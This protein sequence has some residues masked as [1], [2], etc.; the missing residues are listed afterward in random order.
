MRNLVVAFHILRR[1]I[2]IDPT[3]H[4]R[5]ARLGQILVVD[6]TEPPEMVWLWSSRQVFQ[7]HSLQQRA[8]Q[9]LVLRDG[10]VGRCSGIGPTEHEGCTDGW[11]FGS[12]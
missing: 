11:S 2:L 3:N 12:S 7:A 4:Q 8:V 6:S 9:L 1:M 5:N 10:L